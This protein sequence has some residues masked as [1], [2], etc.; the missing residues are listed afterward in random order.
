MTRIL[1]ISPSGEVY[2]HDCVRWYSH[3]DFAVAP[4]HYHNIGDAFVYDSS[5]KLLNFKGLNGLNIRDPSD[6]DIERYNS[7]FAFAVLRG[8][9]YLHPEMDWE[10]APS[11][12]SR[13]RI[14]ILAFGI[15]AQ[16][17]AKGQLELGRDARRV[18]ECIAERCVSFG[19]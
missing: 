2:E 1:V 18:L 5:L 6:A 15:G 10:N 17:P 9:N 13:L 16:A 4:D 14:P 7:E 3:L 8:S 12:L 11:V 19:V